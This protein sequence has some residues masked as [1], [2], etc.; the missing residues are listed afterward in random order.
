MVASI[1]HLFSRVKGLWK[2]I[3]EA[4]ERL[5]QADGEALLQRSYAIEQDEVNS[6]I[7]D[8]AVFLVVET[9]SL[10]FRSWIVLLRC[11]CTNVSVVGRRV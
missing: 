7:E 10:D 9:V 11:V 5:L 3:L 1:F 8:V 6:C 2:D 4:E